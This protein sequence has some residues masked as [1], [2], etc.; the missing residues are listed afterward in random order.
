MGEAG[1][2]GAA[3]PRSPCAGLPG[4]KLDSEVPGLGPWV[5]DLE[6]LVG[7]APLV[8]CKY[9]LG[10]A[11]CPYFFWEDIVEKL[12]QVVGRRGCS[13]RTSGCR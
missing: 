1:S 6:A 12:G 5:W 10:R 13:S 2:S 8:A 3:G 4:T 11:W 7:S 9:T